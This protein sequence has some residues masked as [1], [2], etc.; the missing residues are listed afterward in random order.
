M[1]MGMASD[2]EL[3]DLLDFSAVSTIMAIELLESNF[4]ILYLSSD[5]L[6]WCEYDCYADIFS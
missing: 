3:S 2:K 5:Q 1:G 6:I 4:I